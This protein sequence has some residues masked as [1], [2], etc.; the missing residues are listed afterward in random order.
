ML[1]TLIRLS[2]WPGLCGIL[3]LVMLDSAWVR[4]HVYTVD[5]WKQFLS[6]VGQ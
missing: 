3:S 2:L 4:A 5:G 6:M 1:L